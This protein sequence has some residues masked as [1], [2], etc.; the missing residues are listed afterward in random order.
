MSVVNG[1][2]RRRQAWDRVQPHQRHP[3][4]FFDGDRRLELLAVRNT[5]SRRSDDPEHHFRGAERR[6]H[7][8]R[9]AALI[10]PIV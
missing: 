1:N 9:D 10:R 8:G 6:D 3:Q 2:D 5:S 4:H 7:V